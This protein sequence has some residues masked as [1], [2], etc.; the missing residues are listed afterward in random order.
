MIRTHAILHQATRERDAQGCIIA[1]LADYTRVRGL[2]SGLI[3][4]GVE[5]TV[6]RA[7]RETVEAVENL[8]LFFLAGITMGLLPLAGRL[9]AAPSRVTWPKTFAGQPARS[10]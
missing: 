7:I 8:L 1:T 4:E 6:P 10:T 3:A 5:A 2:V 9:A